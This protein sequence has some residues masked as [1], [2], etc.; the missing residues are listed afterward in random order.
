[1]VVKQRKQQDS[2]DSQHKGESSVSFIQQV[3][4]TQENQYKDQLERYFLLPKAQK[5]ILALRALLPL[6][7]SKKL[8]VDYLSQAFYRLS[9]SQMAQLEK[10]AFSPLVLGTILEHLLQQGLVDGHYLCHSGI[11]QRISQ[12]ALDDNNTAYKNALLTLLKHF[13]DLFQSKEL[14]EKN[15]RLLEINLAIYQN[16]ASY[17]LQAEIQKKRDVFIACIHGL[18]LLFNP[19]QLDL[20]WVK[21]REPTLQFLLCAS[22]LHQHYQRN[23]VLSASS[24]I[25]DW[26]S[27]AKILLQDESF[28][29]ALPF[30][31]FLIPF[32]CDFFLLAGEL[33]F[34]QELLSLPSSGFKQTETPATLA[35]YQQ[36]FA[37]CIEYY[38][39]LE[40]SEPFYFSKK[41]LHTEHP[42]HLLFYLLA[43]VH[44][45]AFSQALTLLKKV[46]IEANQRFYP[47]FFSLKLL[48]K[49]IQQGS[50][51]V[52]GLYHKMLLENIRTA[53][54]LPFN[55]QAFTALLT[56]MLCPQYSQALEKNLSAF[57]SALRSQNLLAAEIYA[58]LILEKKVEAS[59][60]EFINTRTYPL[61]LL[62][63]FALKTS[64]EKALEELENLFTSRQ[65]NATASISENKRLIWLL[66]PKNQNDVP[67]LE[68][69]VQVK[70]QKSW[71][72]ARPVA[73]KL[74]YSLSHPSLS[75]LSAQDRKII[76]EALKK[77]FHEHNTYYSWELDKALPALINHPHLY[78]HKDLSQTLSL[79]Q[80]QVKLFIKKETTGYGLV[81]SHHYPEKGWY[82]E[83]ESAHHYHLV[84]FSEKTLAVDKILSTEGLCIPFEAKDKLLM[85]L[86][87]QDPDLSLSW[88]IDEKDLAQKAG[89]ARCYIQLFPFHEGLTVKLWMKPFGPEE[90]YYPIAAGKKQMLSLLSEQPLQHQMILRDFAKEEAA[91]QELLAHC[92]SLKGL[93]DQ[94]EPHHHECQLPFLESCLSLLEELEA[95][96]ALHNI[97]IEW[98]QGESLKLKTGLCAQQ[99]T[100]SI[101]GKAHWF[102]Y[103][104]QLEIDEEKTISIKELL[105]ALAKSKGTFIQL[106]DFAFITLTARFREQLEILQKSTEDDKI[107]HLNAAVLE[108]F[109][110][111]VAQLTVDENWKKHIQRIK[112]QSTYHPIIPKG[113]KTELRHYQQ[114]GFSYL[115]R[116][117]HWG[118]GACLADDMGLGKTV[119][120]IALLLEQ[121]DKGPALVVCPTSICFTWEE[122]LNRF[123]PQLEVFSL[124]QAENRE[125]CI[126]ALGSNQVLI[127]SYY[128]LCQM[129][130]FLKEKAWQ[131]LILDEAQ[132]I[133]NIDTKRWKAATQLKSHARI[134]LSGTPLEN[135]L[136]ELWG[137][138]HFLNP[139][140]L[141]SKKNF[142][143][144]FIQPIEKS[145]DELS[146]KTLKAVIAPYILRRTK[147]EVLKELPPKIEQTFFIE[148]S[149]EER[150]FYEA[151]RRQ[152]LERLE[153]LTDT[154]AQ[155]KRFSILAEITRLRQSCCDSSLVDPNLT[156]ESSKN[157][158]FLQMVKDLIANEHRALVFSQYVRYLTK[159]R[160]L[161]DAEGIPYEYLDGSTPPLLRQSRIQAFQSGQSPLFLLS[162]KAGGTGLNLTAAD[163]VI[164]LDP[165]WNPAVEDQAAARAHRLGQQRTVNVYRLIVKDSIEEKII[166]L[167]QDKR[168]LADELLNNKAHSA[169]L[170]EEDLLRLIVNSP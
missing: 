109:S 141:G 137:L 122:E 35:F 146:K 133:K 116:L 118:I 71:G 123:A 117:S 14:I 69:K 28:A 128:F 149:T 140:L 41:I 67:E 39:S 61:H 126:E 110:D 168:D 40:K 135:H 56:S 93:D 106:S 129:E 102:E 151:L 77:N 119:Q 144:N 70:T 105:D 94:E 78:Y 90:G 143:Q 107:Y 124:Q 165:W 113:L 163:Y 167:H 2:K 82:L 164:I 162:L 83:Q 37:K 32:F 15:T 95:Y 58:E 74:L 125:A 85:T 150:A 169:Q 17:F 96:K 101:Q 7:C 84:Y 6:H 19:E 153:R 54:N 68:A 158:S 130:P 59:C 49:S 131:V 18:A 27:Y 53:Q 103:Q 98:P 161:L 159:I 139:G 11:Q 108:N 72:K 33:S 89:D 97:F 5:T 157:K 100:M 148:L 112:T 10:N 142:Q 12:L 64:W 79:S 75:Y 88:D 21:T 65:D 145:K 46:L 138:F 45:A 76:S 20:N 120:S 30:P 91:Y 73:L 3:T 50:P 136:G 170:S 92:P 42:L 87:N 55:Y 26:L 152:A 47:F 57:H 44:E 115:S 99:L 31:S 66:T 104:G 114:E 9:P 60:L 22:R 134:A 166:K 160:A 34:I 81:L 127:C 86:Q 29:K 121:A 154:A 155:T 147:A 1:M 111:N 25:K 51:A 43:L 156:I 38:Q 4:T 80:A 36:D 52:L 16:E 62:K 23:E 132:A 8:F 48:I 13:Q 24:N 63:N